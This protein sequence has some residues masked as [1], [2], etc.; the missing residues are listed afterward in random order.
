MRTP[1]KREPKRPERFPQFESCGMEGCVSGWRQ[2]TSGKAYRCAC[3]L[4]FVDRWVERLKVGGR[5]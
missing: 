1:K 5:S 2:D 3:W 4:A